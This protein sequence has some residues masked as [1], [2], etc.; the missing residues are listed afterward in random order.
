MIKK[1]I[2]ALTITLIWLLANLLIMY[3]NKLEFLLLV[4]FVMII[5]VFILIL[6]E[7]YNLKF[8]NWLNKKI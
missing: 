1:D 6:F 3:L 2:I 7:K 5:L 8:R 4:T